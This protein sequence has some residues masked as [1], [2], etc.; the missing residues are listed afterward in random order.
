MSVR[1]HNMT[2]FVLDFQRAGCYP[3]LVRL[4]SGSA[5]LSILSDY[6]DM[7]GYALIAMG[8][9]RPSISKILSSIRFPITESECI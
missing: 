1:L 5:S 4:P 2:Y 9:S 8:D 7:N 3:E 6:C